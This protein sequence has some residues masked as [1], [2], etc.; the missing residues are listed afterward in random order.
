MTANKIKFDG[1]DAAELAQVGASLSNAIYCLT[2]GSN[3]LTADLKKIRRIA[4]SVKEASFD[5]GEIDEAGNCGDQCA[6]A[7][8]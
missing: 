1:M 7:L 5:R 2:D 4:R 3:R 8:R 6:C